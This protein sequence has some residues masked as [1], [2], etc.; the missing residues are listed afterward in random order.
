M[1][2]LEIDLKSIFNNV[3]LN[4]FID[5]IHHDRV[6]HEDTTRILLKQYLPS[7]FN[8]KLTMVDGVTNDELIETQPLLYLLQSIANNE[9]NPKERERAAIIYKNQ[10]GDDSRFE[11]NYAYF[12][13]P[14]PILTHLLIATKAWSKALGHDKEKV[15]YDSEMMGTLLGNISYKSGAIISNEHYVR[16]KKANSKL[17]TKGKQQANGH[18]VFS[19]KVFGLG[20]RVDLAEWLD[21]I[22]I[23]SRRIQQHQLMALFEEKL[24]LTSEKLEHFFDSDKKCVAFVIGSIASG[25]TTYGDT[26]LGFKENTG[27][28][29]TLSA[30]SLKGLMHTL[31]FLKPASDYQYNNSDFHFESCALSKL[32]LPKKDEFKNLLVTGAYIDDRFQDALGWYKDRNILVI[33]IATSTPLQAAKQAFHRDMHWQKQDNFNYVINSANSAQ[34]NRQS[35]INA[36]TAQGFHYKLICNAPTETRKPD[37]TLVLEINNK[38]SAIKNAQLLHELTDINAVCDEA[39]GARAFNT[40]SFPQPIGSVTASPAVMFGGG[41]PVSGNSFVSVNKA[42]ESPTANTLYSNRH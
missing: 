21:R 23:P 20:C 36:A 37:F 32:I 5:A 25:K 39:E 7:A 17:D 13:S 22:Y 4:E 10:Y 35:R 2:N 24:K 15:S 26:V 19:D 29:V 11:L 1:A 12:N 34:Q 18:F 33:E 42:S 16:L 27:D 31:D 38:Q 41:G 40:L 14:L 28:S 3:N 30:D 6:T 8:G 9:D